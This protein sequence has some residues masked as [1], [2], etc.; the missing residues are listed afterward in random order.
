[1]NLE[2]LGRVHKE[3]LLTGGAVHEAIV[4]IA[5]RVN[6]KVQIL[7]LHWQASALLQHMDQ[8]TGD[9]GRQ[10]ADYLSRRQP[11]KAPSDSPADVLEPVL[12]RAALRIQDSKQSLVQ[13]DVRIRELKLESIH[14]NLLQLQR[15]LSLRSSAIER[16]ATA[17]GAPAVGQRLGDGPRPPSVHIATIMRGPFLL[18]PSEQ[19]VL[20]ADDIVVLIGTQADLDQFTPWLTSQRP[21]RSG[22]EPR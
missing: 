16:V 2:L 10:L 18:A 9:L 8:A 20:R 15:D 11:M 14:Y 19:L 22:T 4:A 17:R 7:R 1:M 6:R 5:E 12:A 3:L 13:I 21:G